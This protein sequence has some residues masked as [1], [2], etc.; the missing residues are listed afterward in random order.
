MAPPAPPQSTPED[1][2][3]APASVEASTE[4]VAPTPVTDAEPPPPVTDSPSAMVPATIP[5]PVNSQA[6]MPP[7][8]SPKEKQPAKTASNP[9]STATNADHP[10]APER[11]ARNVDP[12]PPLEGPQHFKLVYGEVD[13]VIAF[14]T[15]GKMFFFVEDESDS[16]SMS[17]PPGGGVRL[18]FYGAK[19][20]PHNGIYFTGRWSD[21]KINGESD[22]TRSISFGYSLKKISSKKGA[23]FRPGFGLDAGLIRTQ[24]S[25]MADSDIDFENDTYTGLELFPRFMVDIVAF[26]AGN[27]KMV[28]PISIG[29]YVV[30]FSFMKLLDDPFVLTMFTVVQPAMTIGISF[31]G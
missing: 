24:N 12:P 7:A 19:G 11:I 4:S 27:F 3:P 8:A 9:T 28:V 31:G 18:A 26:N 5:D 22:S 20:N 6:H 29:L 30:P 2:R 21:L 25:D 14:G 16:E 10:V 13:G 15:A 23:R 1:N 17:G